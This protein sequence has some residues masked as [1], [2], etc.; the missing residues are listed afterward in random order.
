ML[1]FFA[2]LRMRTLPTVFQQILEITPGVQ[3]KIRVKISPKGARVLFKIARERTPGARNRRA[4]H[5]Q[6]EQTQSWDL[7]VVEEPFLEK[8][9]VK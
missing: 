5:L 9:P 3:P 8:L 1:R 7:V 2:A 4:V 6:V